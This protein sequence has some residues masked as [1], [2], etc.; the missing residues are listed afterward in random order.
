M[1]DG[2]GGR[3]GGDD[4]KPRR[5]EGSKGNQRQ[6]KR[7]KAGYDRHSRDTGIP[8]RLRNIHC[9]KRN[10]GNSVSYDAG[11][12]YR[13][14]ALKQIQQILGSCLGDNADFQQRLSHS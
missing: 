6:Q 2:C 7:I 8:K 1:K 4:Q 13:L 12:L 11:S 3:V 5:T 10:P 14:H 9:G